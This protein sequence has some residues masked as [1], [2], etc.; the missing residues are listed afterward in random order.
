MVSTR[1]NRK[2]GDEISLLGFGGMR[3]PLLPGT[4]E[5][6]E[7]QV[8]EMVELAIQ[9]G[10]N[11]FDTAFP[12]HG[13]KSEVVLGRVLNDHPRDRYFLADKLPL[14][15]L[16]TPQDVDDMFE[17]QLKKC[18]KAHFD[19]YL[20]HSLCVPT[21]DAAKRTDAYRVLERKKRE[22]KIRNL[23]FS[24]HDRLPLLKE[25]V[26][27][28]DWDFAQLQINYVDWVAIGAKEMYQCLADAGIPVAVMEPLRGGA[29]VNLP[30]QA[31]EE[32]ERATPHA[33]P[34]SWG[35]RFAASLPNV[36]TVLSGMSSTEQV[37]ENVRNLSD[38]APLSS[39][40]NA[41]LDR[42]RILYQSAS[43]IPCTGCRYCMPCPRGVNIPGNFTAYNIYRGSGNVNWVF[44]NAYFGLLTEQ[45]FSSN[46]VS[47]GLCEKKC[48]QHIRIPHELKK[49]RMT[50][51]KLKD[52]W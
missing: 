23:G 20:M 12:Y 41:M 43:T 21:W 50:A 13:G 16:K 9:N 30:K 18:G 6:D 22:G 8:A 25:I 15:E 27:A 47:C 29:L 51:E 26:R 46:C 42:I 32:L 3:F 35:L 7:R 40:E 37:A 39:E 44:L 24:F 36:M 14:W 1:K 4:E 10:V 11:Y 2:S 52:G 34:A 17:L 48:P 45:E 5:I 31:A 19:Y 33:T 38:F 28:C 49:V